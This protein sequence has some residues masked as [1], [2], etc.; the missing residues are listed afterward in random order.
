MTNKIIALD[1]IN[2]E[3]LHETD[4]LRLIEE[5]QTLSQTLEDK[6]GTINLLERGGL[7]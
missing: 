1:Y 5:L 2:R 4:V 6:E 7:N 3:S